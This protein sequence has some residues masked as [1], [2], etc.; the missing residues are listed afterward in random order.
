MI[1]KF[2]ICICS[3]VFE[4]KFLSILTF[5]SI[6]ANVQNVCILAGQYLECSIGGIVL[7]RSSPPE[8]LCK[9]VVLKNFTKFTGKHLCQSL[10]FNKIAGLRPATLLKETLACNFVKKETLAQ[11]LSCEFCEI[12]KSTVFYRTPPVATSDSRSE[13]CTL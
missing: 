9:K 4:Q 6:I 1:C 11:V 2:D 5:I 7:S 10:L 3:L 13:Y 12:F 8:V